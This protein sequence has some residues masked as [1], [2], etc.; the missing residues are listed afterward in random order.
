MVRYRSNVRK[1]FSPL[2]GDIKPDTPYVRILLKEAEC[3]V[4]L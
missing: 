2:L 4:Q 1:Y 3:E